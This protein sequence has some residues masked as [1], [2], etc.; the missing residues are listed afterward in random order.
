MTISNTVFY[1]ILIDC[2]V[3][4]IFSLIFPNAF[5]GHY[6]VAVGLLGMAFIVWLLKKLGFYLEEDN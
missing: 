4:L 6:L 1:I 5:I 2:F 3:C